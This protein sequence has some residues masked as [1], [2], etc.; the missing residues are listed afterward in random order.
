MKPKFKWSSKLIVDLHENQD[1]QHDVPVTVK[2]W[3]ESVRAQASIMFIGLSDGSHPYPLQ[4]VFTAEVGKIR[5]QIEPQAFIGA[6]M[7]ATGVIV[8]SRGK[9]QAIE[10][11]VSDAKIIGPI[12][13]PKTFIP[14]MKQQVLG[15]D[16]VR[17]AHDQRALIP[18]YKS[19]N[20]IRDE[21]MCGVQTFFKHMRVLHLDP[22]VITKNRLNCNSKP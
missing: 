21:L 11:L 3:I 2:G 15:L 16:L 20:R 4:L 8:T 19:I 12:E 14:S 7:S 6:T 18:A 17:A 22:N 10:M 9:G 13:N 1:F 5:Q